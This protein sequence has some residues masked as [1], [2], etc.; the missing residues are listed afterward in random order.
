MGLIKWDSCE[1]LKLH[2]VHD[3]EGLEEANRVVVFPSPDVDR[4]LASSRFGT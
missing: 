2:K 4:N 1:I 3:A